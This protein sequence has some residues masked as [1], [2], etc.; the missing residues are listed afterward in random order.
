M[1]NLPMQVVDLTFLTCFNRLKAERSFDRF[2]VR[3]SLGV[4]TLG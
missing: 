1:L 2:W 3:M 4:K